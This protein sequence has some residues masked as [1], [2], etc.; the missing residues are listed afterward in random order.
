MDINKEAATALIA[1]VNQP[2]R[3]LFTEGNT[4]NRADI[5]RA[6]EATMQAFGSLNSVIA[7]A[8]IHRSNTLLDITDE[9]L[10]LM[11]QT[12]IYGTVNTLREAVPHLI[13]AGGGTVVINASDQWFVGKAHSFAYGLTK[14]ALGQITRSLSIDLG[15]KNIRVNAVC[16]GTIHTPLVDN[17]FQKF[18]EVN[19]CSIDDYWREENALYARGSVGKPEEVAEMIYFLASDASSF[20]TGGHYLVDGGLVAH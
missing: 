16:A 6:V 7:N 17:L 3:L 10:D 19:H 11:I 18:A 2:E 15:P 5:H 9:E 12:N 20:C 14:G 8:G 1:E 13:E 4:R